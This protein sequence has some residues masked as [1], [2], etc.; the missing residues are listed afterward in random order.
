M[1]RARSD[2]SGN[3]VMMMAKITEADSAPPAP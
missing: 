1:A 2:V 3:S